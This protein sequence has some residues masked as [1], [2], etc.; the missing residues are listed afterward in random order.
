MKKKKKAKQAFPRG[1]NQE[2][3]QEVI[4]H[5]E[6]QSKEAQAAEIEAA[7]GVASITMIGVPTEL[8]REVHAFVKKRQGGYTPIPRPQ[9]ARRRT[10]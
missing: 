6:R 1:W 5:Y 2:R 8:V 4:G 7:H 3:V 10:G 9:P